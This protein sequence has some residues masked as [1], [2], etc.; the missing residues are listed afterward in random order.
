MPHLRR[1]LPTDHAERAGE[2]ASHSSFINLARS[3]IFYA[4][5]W[6][7]KP[8]N[9]TKVGGRPWSVIVSVG[10]S[11]GE[12]LRARRSCHERREWARLARVTTSSRGWAVCCAVWGGPQ[13][14]VTISRRISLSHCRRSRQRGQSL[15]TT[16]ERG[17]G[18]GKGGEQA[19]SVSESG[20]N[21]ALT[22]RG[23]RLERLS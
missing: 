11:D 16:G 2:A 13:E 4:A 14:K 9:A 8:K 3:C 17:G 19:E 21:T 22:R 6:K 15:H 12:A 10:A 5:A 18:S 1:L 7:A 20:Q 23:F